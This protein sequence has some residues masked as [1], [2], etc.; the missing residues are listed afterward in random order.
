[1]EQQ[2]YQNKHVVSYS[3]RHIVSSKSEN[4]RSM[5]APSMSILLNPSKFDKSLE[6]ANKP[7]EKK[8]NLYVNMKI[9]YAKFTYSLWISKSKET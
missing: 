4:T 9:V 3:V 8:K 1:M 2:I 5:V 7:I 6:I